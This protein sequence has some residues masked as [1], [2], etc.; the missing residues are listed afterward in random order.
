[1]DTIIIVAIICLLVGGGICF[2]IFQT[3]NKKA[4]KEYEAEAELLKKN[5]MIEAK[6]HFIAL[7]A[8]HEQQVQQK[9]SRL[10][11]MESKLQSREMQLNQRHSEIQRKYSEAE[12]VKETYTQQISAVEAKKRELEHATKQ[13]QEQL[14]NISGLSTEQAKEQLIESLKDEAKTNAM[15]YINEIMEEAKMTANK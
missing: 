10:Q 7:K 6:E 11:S 9:N 13:I 3:I 4:A 12:A 5:K 1:M 15:S 14:E 8:E 2:G